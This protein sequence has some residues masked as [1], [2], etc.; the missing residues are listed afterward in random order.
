MTPERRLRASESDNLNFMLY[1][2]ERIS[3]FRVGQ[4]IW[5]LELNQEL[6]KLLIPSE[7]TTGRDRSIIC[8]F[9]RFYI[10]DKAVMPRN[11]TFL[12]IWVFF[13]YSVS[14]LERT[15]PDFQ[16]WFNRKVYIR[17]SSIV[18]QKLFSMI[19]RIEKEAETIKEGM[20]S[21]WN[22]SGIRRFLFIRGR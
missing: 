4:R 19:Y 22:I 1:C 17:Q 15:H 9:K 6:L 12:A 16:V 7:G 13:S 3:I 11:F 21:C 5:T 2:R 14:Q 10:F 18:F 8:I 20:N